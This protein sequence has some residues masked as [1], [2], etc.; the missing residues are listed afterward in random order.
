MLKCKYW[1][2]N[3]ILARKS[4]DK[5]SPSPK[6]NKIKERKENVTFVTLKMSHFSF[7]KHLMAFIY[8]SFLFSVQFWF[9]F[10][11]NNVGFIL[12]VLFEL[13]FQLWAVNVP[14]RYTVFWIVYSFQNTLGPWFFILCIFELCTCLWSWILA[15]C[16]VAIYLKIL[17]SLSETKGIIRAIIDYNQLLCLSLLS[18]MISI[19]T[20]LLVTQNF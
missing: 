4:C 16:V 18:G 5:I 13:L 17:Q 11:R 10:Y 9:L 19:K 1:N 6:K 20:S 12:W 14:F 3:T 7:N 2:K 8:F 15:H